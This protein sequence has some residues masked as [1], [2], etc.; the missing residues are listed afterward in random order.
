MSSPKS[1]E[2]TCV[3]QKLAEEMVEFW[4]KSNVHSCH[5]CVECFCLFCRYLVMPSIDGRFGGKR[6]RKNGVEWYG[7]VGM[8]A[9][10]VRFPI[11][12]FKHSL[13][14]SIWTPCKYYKA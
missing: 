2:D 5:K 1:M 11:E 10:N 4:T 8:M 3:L 13:V 6:K 7:L 14:G 9:R 12:D